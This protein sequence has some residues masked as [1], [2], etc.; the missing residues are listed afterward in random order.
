MSPV[1]PGLIIPEDAGFGATVTGLARVLWS[2][3]D[4][5]G[6]QGKDRRVFY[7]FIVVGQE[8]LR[9]VVRRVRIGA[10]FP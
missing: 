1:F 9:A 7:Y 6:A 2:K 3:G 8:G 4:A 5:Y 10:C